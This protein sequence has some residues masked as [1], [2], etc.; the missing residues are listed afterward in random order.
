MRPE[1]ESPV[2]TVKD[3]K[4]SANRNSTFEAVTDAFSIVLVSAGFTLLSLGLNNF[5]TVRMLIMCI[6]FSA[7]EI[8]CL[9]LFRHSNLS[10]LPFERDQ[11]TAA[12]VIQTAAV[13][14]GTYRPL[15]RKMSLYKDTEI[16]QHIG[17]AIFTLS[18]VVD[19]INYFMTAYEVIPFGTLLNP[20]FPKT[21][22]KSDLALE[23]EKAHAVRGII[24]VCLKIVAFGFIFIFVLKTTVPRKTKKTEKTQKVEE[25]KNREFNL[26]EWKQKFGVE[27]TDSIMSFEPSDAQASD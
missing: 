15:N 18:W 9:I 27:N 24:A 25:P 4:F 12:I 11:F 5:G 19:L 17:V 3:G 7:L 26:D 1:L 2:V 21:M 6:S 23:I 8:A 22:R 14:I 10:A 16:L 13:L 20:K